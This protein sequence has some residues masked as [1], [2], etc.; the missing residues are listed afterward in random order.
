MPTDEE[1]NAATPQYIT[2]NDLIG[3]KIPTFLMG[4]APTYHK[5]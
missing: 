2:S 5:L 4:W 3:V 1:N